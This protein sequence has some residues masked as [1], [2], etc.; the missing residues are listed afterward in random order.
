MPRLLPEISQDE[1]DKIETAYDVLCEIGLRCN[2]EFWLVDEAHQKL[3]V[4]LAVLTARDMGSGAL[5]R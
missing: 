1:R 4:F 3:G 2:W 5:W